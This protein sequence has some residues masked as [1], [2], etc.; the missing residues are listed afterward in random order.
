VHW[1]DIDWLGFTGEN[2]HKIEL[3]A[4]LVGS[5]VLVTLVL[6]GIMRHVATER[7]S[8]V[9]FWS[10]QAISVVT[11]GILALGLVSI[12]VTRTES[13]TAL[14]GMITAGLAFA[15]QKVITSFA[16]YFIIL[17]GKNFTVGDRI[18][19]GGV[20]GDVIDVGF[21]QTTIMEMGQPKDPPDDTWV[22]GRQFTGR[23]VTVANSTIFEEPIFNYTK[24]FPVL[25]EEIRMNFRFDVDRDAVER[26]AIA[27]AMPFAN[28]REMLDEE[29]LGRIRH[30]FDVSPEALEPKVY[31]R[32]LPKSLEATLRFII[33]AHRD[34]ETKDDI[35]RALLSAINE[36]GIAIGE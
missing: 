22:R 6:R 30:R 24:D 32:I 17:R 21:F 34:R 18:S 4:L 3:T 23:I 16:G 7:F 20:R 33:A 27:S 36:R 29:Q 19:M 11:S 25:W 8:A 28:P 31:F 26:I 14:L 5:V 12:W 1:L 15:L 35:A 13:L 9:N 10:R 2:L